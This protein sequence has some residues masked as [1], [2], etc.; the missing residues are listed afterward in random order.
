MAPVGSKTA[1]EHEI[2]VGTNCLGPYLFTQ[3][4]LPQLREAAKSAPEAS[5]RI[6]WTSSMMVDALAPWGGIDFAEL[7]APSSDQNRNYAIS[8]AGNWLLASEFARRVDGDG[9]LS[10]TTAQ[11][12][13]GP[14]RTTVC[15][16]SCCWWHRPSSTTPFTALIPGCGSACRPTLSRP[17]LGD[18]PF[19][20]DGGIYRHGRILRQ[21]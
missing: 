8:K 18:T 14:K 7:A 15:P 4:L 11:D 10:L 12:C 3:L 19:R 21:A 20:G 2:H 16:R 17:T 1:Q 5:V 6:V 13:S 9:I